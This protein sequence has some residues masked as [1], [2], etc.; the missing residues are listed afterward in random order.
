M[1]R[2]NS[3]F[4]TFKDGALYI[5]HQ[6]F[7]FDGNR[8]RRN[9]F[10]GNSHPSK[11][12]VLC[13]INPSNNKVFNGVSLEGS[14]AWS[15]NDLKTNLVKSIAT[16]TGVNA[17]DAIRG[18]F[19]ENIKGV[20]IIAS[21]AGDATVTGTGTE[22]TTS[23]VV[24]DVLRYQ[25]TELGEVA[26]ITND[27]SLEL[28]QNATVTLANE[29]CFVQ[30][31]FTE[32]AEKE[33]MFYAAFKY[34]SIPDLNS[35]D[36]KGTN[37]IGLGNVSINNNN[38]GLTGINF[39]INLKVG[40]V[41]RHGDGGTF[42]GVVE[43]ITNATTAVLEAAYTGPNLADQY[44]YI[45]ENPIVEGDRFRG[46]YLRANLSCGTGQKMELFATNFNLSLSE[47]SNR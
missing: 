1:A 43:S 41:I 13:N 31:S 42:I 37:L 6:D 9:F 3:D 27:T 44:A 20:G 35:Q 29:Y 23:L 8:I 32:L 10:Y 7:D 2:I 12:H 33:G 46:Y 38:T 14:H 21:T 17:V 16:Q 25:N 24:G 30:E 26:T 28:T 18:S 34:A 40:D 4:I 19:G 39:D 45:E 36:N 22:F 47:L 11:L 15:V 5:H